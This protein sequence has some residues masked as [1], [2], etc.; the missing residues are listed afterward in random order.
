MIQTT[1]VIRLILGLLILFGAG[2]VPAQASAAVPYAGAVDPCST[3]DFYLRNATVS[4]VF[5]D[6]ANWTNGTR[7]LGYLDPGEVVRFS[8]APGAIEFWATDY[9]AY[10]DVGG[11]VYVEGCTKV[12]AYIKNVKKP[13]IKIFTTTY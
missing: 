2:V 5:V 6:V 11:W 8:L 1:K 7:W 13:V 4:T 12:D 10:W 3:V 9:D